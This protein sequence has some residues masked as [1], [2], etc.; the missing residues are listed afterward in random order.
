MTHTIGRF[1]QY[2]PLLASGAQPTESEIK[3]LKE[4]GFQ[5]IVNISPSSAGN[6]LH[7]EALVVEHL[8][9]DYVHVPIDYNNL[10]PLYYNIFK[11][12]MNGLKDKK[13]FVHC[14]GNIKASNFL[15]MYDVM[16]NN[17]DEVES[18]K[19]LRRI[20][21]PEEKWFVY[22]RMLGMK[23]ISSI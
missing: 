8:S 10:R 19:T 15:H 9:M 13:V 12:I 7:N 11:G 6:F 14:G 18:L 5:A 22:F 21:N 2:T 16:E 20:Q 17:I 23:G 3:L 1:Y 4:D